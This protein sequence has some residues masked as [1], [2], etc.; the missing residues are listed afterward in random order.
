MNRY[1]ITVLT[2]QGNCLTFKEVESYEIL[3]GDIIKF[4]DK[5]SKKHKRFHSSR[6]EIEE[7]KYG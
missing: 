5:K 6:V 4:F 2:L 3:E 7:E 1:R